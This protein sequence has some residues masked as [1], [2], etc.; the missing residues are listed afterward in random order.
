M[1]TILTG[2]PFPYQTVNIYCFSIALV[3]QGFPQCISN[4][5]FCAGAWLV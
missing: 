5:A 1:E 3:V 4:G 2:Q